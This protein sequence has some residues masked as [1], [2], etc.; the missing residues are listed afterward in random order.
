[1]TDKQFKRLLKKYQA[2]NCTPEE[3]K[4]IRQWY[5]SFDK[6]EDGIEQ[7]SQTDKAALEDKIIR[8]IRSHMQGSSNKKTV[9]LI[10]YV[11]ISVAALFLILIGYFSWSWIQ[12]LNDSN[13]FITSRSRGSIK[14][15]MLPDGTLVWLKGN[16]R[17][18]YPKQ[19]AQHAPEREVLLT[20]EALF[21]VAKNPRQPFFIQCGRVEAK[22]LGTSF[23]IREIQ[24]DH[25]VE[26]VVLTGKVALSGKEQEVNNAKPMV[27]EP[28]QRAIAGR[29]GF[30]KDSVQAISM[31]VQGTA[32]DMRFDETSL[33]EVLERIEQKFDVEII[34]KDVG[35]NCRITA[36][37]TD[38]SLQVTLQM[39]AF[40]LGEV[41][42]YLKDKKVFLEGKACQ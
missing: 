41:S 21:E 39:M 9:P 28:M 22:V 12:E 7:L 30:S 17:L 36:D 16:S 19:F 11:K 25:Q 35:Q 2:G 29:E 3:E 18:E 38:Q 40:T 15:I 8:K 4:L 14:K 33:K 5:E 24:E 32:Y 26:V 23:N 20:G 42:Y 31:Y 27:V 34:Y 10:P 6:E 37:F 13:Q 1:M